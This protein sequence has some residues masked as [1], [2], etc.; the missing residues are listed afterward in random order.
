MSLNIAYRRVVLGLSPGA[1]PQRLEFRLRSHE[2]LLAEN[3][4]RLVNGL[5]AGPYDRT[6]YAR[7]SQRALDANSPRSMVFGK[8][9]CGGSNTNGRAFRNNALVQPVRTET[10]DFE[11]TTHHGGFLPSMARRRQPFGASS[12]LSASQGLS[13]TPAAVDARRNRAF[14]QHVDRAGHTQWAHSL[15]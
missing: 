4:D 6:S 12:L 13:S 1:P 9:D 14:G 3:M 7:W 15:H 2:N 5:T 11:P 8:L 10:L